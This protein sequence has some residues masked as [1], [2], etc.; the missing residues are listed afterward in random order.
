MISV[1]AKQR[2]EVEEADQAGNFEVGFIH[3]QELANIHQ[4][5]FLNLIG[6]EAA[7]LVQVVMAPAAGDRIVLG[8]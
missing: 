5:V 3:A 8:R 6:G 4:V 2:V 1:T 7:N